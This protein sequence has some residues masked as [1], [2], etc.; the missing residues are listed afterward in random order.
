MVTA[1]LHY[2][3]ADSLQKVKGIGPA[4]AEVLGEREIYT[5]QDLLLQ[6]P[7]RYE[8][9]SQILTIED[10]VVAANLVATSAAR[11]EPVTIQAT[12]K[13]VSQFYRGRRSILQATIEDETGQLNCYWFNAPYLKTKLIIGQS[14]FFAGTVT[15]NS[16]TNK[17]VFTQPAVEALTAETIHTGRLVPL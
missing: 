8:D 3:L 7:L 17:P 1:T 11:G 10:A 15:L 9:R 6:L 13:K 5:I 16:K 14:F 4:V 12:V 2:Q